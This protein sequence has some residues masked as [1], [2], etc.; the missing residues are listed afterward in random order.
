MLA[1]MPRRSFYAYVLLALLVAASSVRLTGQESLGD[2]ARRI[3][4]GKGED[5]SSPAGKTT[6]NPVAKKAKPQPAANAAD[7]NATMNLLSE[8]DDVAYATRVRTQLEQENFRV[9]DDVAAAER[10][11]KTRFGGG[12]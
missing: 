5:A 3:R 2:A 6:A 10:S 8:R 9:L 11:G 12:G 4:E 7:V 1:G